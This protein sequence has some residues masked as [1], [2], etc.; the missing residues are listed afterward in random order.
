MAPEEFYYYVEHQRDCADFHIA[1]D[2]FYSTNSPENRQHSEYIFERLRQQGHI[3]TRPVAALLRAGCT[4]LPDRFIRGTC[5]SQMPDQYGDV[6][7]VVA[8]RTIRRT[9]RTLC[10]LRHPASDPRVR[11]L[12]LHAQCL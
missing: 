10:H 12:F 6:C 3:V 2:C 11:T 4:V 9:S 8:P 7:E 1:F 5:K